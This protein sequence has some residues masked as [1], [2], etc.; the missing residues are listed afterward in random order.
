MSPRSEDSSSEG[1]EADNT[2]FCDDLDEHICSDFSGLQPYSFEHE[3]LDV[4][5][6]GDSDDASD[7]EEGKEG[8]EVELEKLAGRKDGCNYGDCRVEE[9][10]VDCLNSTVLK[11]VLVCLHES[12]GGSFRGRNNKQ[13]CN[14]MSVLVLR[15]FSCFT[16]IILK[17]TTFF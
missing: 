2:N 17:S 14:F 4:I 7:K 8:V 5:S 6:G 3:R 10:E 13:V 11:N 12:R 15:A 1:E 9:R 16:I